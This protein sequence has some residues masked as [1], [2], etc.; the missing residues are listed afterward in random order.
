MRMVAGGSEQYNPPMCWT[1]LIVGI[2]IGGPMGFVVCAFL[3]NAAD[4]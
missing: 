1:A 2:F 3:H 4:K